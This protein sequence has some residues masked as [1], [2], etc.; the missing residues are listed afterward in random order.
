MAENFSEIKSNW[1]LVLAPA[2]PSIEE[3]NRIRALIYHFDRMVP[4]A[5]LGSTIE[6]RNLL[7][8]MGFT[9]ICIFEKNKDFYEW[10]CTW[11]THDVNCEHVIWGDWLE[12]IHN[13]N[14]HFAV[15]L[16]DE[17]MGF[18]SYN[19]RNIFYQ[20]VFNS[21]IN[22]GLFIDKELTHC[23]P[24]IPLDNLMKKYLTMPINLE[25]INRFT[26]EVLFCST[27]LN[28]EIVDTSKFYKKLQDTYTSPILRK[29][30]ELAHLIIPENCIWF[31]GKMW[32]EIKMD[33]YKPYE[34]IIIYEDIPSSPYFGRVKQFIN[35][36]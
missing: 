23:I 11:I 5:V 17:T 26:C 15:V 9:N 2:R 13:F 29:Y 6:F 34:D 24:H 3:I 1:Q 25:T 33:Y 4:V 20:S 12:T 18:I 22:G 21:I 8:D 30:I 27:L 35:I 31:Y 16:S 10:T 36:K 19:E 14:S 32:D 28:Y 7:H